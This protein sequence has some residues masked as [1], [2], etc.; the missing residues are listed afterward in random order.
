MNKIQKKRTHVPS[1][2]IAIPLALILRAVILVIF[3][4]VAFGSDDP[5]SL[6]DTAAYAARLIS[7]L[8]SGII[9]AKA[10]SG[11]FN[12]LTKVTLAAVVSAVI[13]V[14]EMLIG[15]ALCGG[16]PTGLFMIPTAIAVCALGAALASK[17]KN[18]KKKKRKPR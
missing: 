16:T 5:T 2:L 17:K 12:P 10:V 15:K 1:P 7:E 18:V 11:G 14:A 4:A 8:I 6:I 9:I 3:A 13:N